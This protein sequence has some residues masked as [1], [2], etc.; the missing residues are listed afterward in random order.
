MNLRRGCFLALL[1]GVGALSACGDSTDPELESRTTDLANPTEVSVSGEFEAGPKAVIVYELVRKRGTDGKEES[2]EYGSADVATL[3][4]VARPWSYLGEALVYHDQYWSS[5]DEAGNV[6]EGYRIFRTENTSPIE[7]IWPAGP[8]QIDEGLEETLSKPGSRVSV[9]INLKHFPNWNI[10]P[11]PG[12]ILAVEDLLAATAER[13]QL[14]AERQ[15]LYNSLAAP[16]L[17]AIES[18]GGSITATGS[19]SGWIEA[20]IGAETLSA[21]A[22]REDIYNVVAESNEGRG[23]QWGVGDGRIDSRM[24]VQ[25]FHS[26]GFTGEQSNSTRHAFG[27]ITI[28]VADTRLEDEACFLYDNSACTGTSRLQE[29]LDC[30]DLD[31]DGDLCETVTNF[32][33]TE[34]DASHG[35]KVTS[36]A[37]GDYE[38]GQADGFQVGDS[39]WTSGTHAT[40]WE[41]R[42]SGMAPEARLISFDVGNSTSSNN[43]ASNAALAE[44]FAE[45]ADRNV[46]IY[47][48]SWSNGGTA[49]AP[50]STGV[51][52][53]ELE[54][55][56]D[57]GVFVVVAAG[58]NTDAN[59]NCSPTDY[60]SCSIGNP[61]DTLKAFAVN[62]FNSAASACEADYNSC[63]WHHCFYRLGGIP[64]KVNGISHASIISGIGIVAP[65]SVQ[66]GTTSNLGPYGTADLSFTGTSA[67]APHV[68]GAAALVKDQYLAAGNTWINNPGFLNVLM[69]GMTDRRYE[70]SGTPSRLVTGLDDVYGPGNIRMRLVGTGGGLGAAGASLFTLSFTSASST[71]SSTLFGGPLPAGTDILK[72]VLYQVEDMSPPKD[73]VSDIDLE[74]EIRDKNTLGTCSPPGPLSGMGRR[75]S[76]LDTVSLVSIPHGRGGLDGKCVRLNVIPVS[77]TSSGVTTKTYCQYA[78]V[79]DYETPL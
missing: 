7:T 23:F 27:D 78:Q 6:D 39:S 41:T 59:G 76:S 68:A 31:G 19:R 24:G 44:T 69:L 56:F 15:E 46:D 60:S 11:L 2:W 35:T 51:V 66:S 4:R 73:S 49:C 5:V 17:D 10:P 21:L 37:L 71:W 47:S 34:A 42:N 79:A 16:I 77:V 3:Q 50:T 52:E 55:A 25:R 54:N 75:D 40:T 43:I 67:A 63:F 58:N 57:D 1:G 70:V 28:A 48:A 8:P 38:D 45:A 74:L 65:S 13:S 29:R 62:G 14:L 32:A 20:D 12:Q 33:D 72:C 18:S 36:I 26:N 22:A 61:A 30:F 53:Q 9:V 64:G